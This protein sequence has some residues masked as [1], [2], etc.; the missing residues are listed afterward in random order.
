MSG[1]SKGSNIQSVNQKTLYSLVVPVPSMNE[2]NRILQEVSEYERQIEKS[3]EVILGYTE[4]KKAVL[5]H[6]LK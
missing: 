5:E 1:N 3:Q 2:Q 6:Y 4:R